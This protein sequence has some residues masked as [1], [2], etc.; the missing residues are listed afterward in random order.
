MKRCP[1]GPLLCS[2]AGDDKRDSINLT[3]IL[4]SVQYRL[5]PITSIGFSPNIRI[6]WMAGSRNRLT[7]PA[8]IGGS[9]FLSLLPGDYR[10]SGMGL[11]CHS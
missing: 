10:V 2:V 7:L 3:D 11:N 4:Y 1:C 5:T 9:T 6:N 8:G